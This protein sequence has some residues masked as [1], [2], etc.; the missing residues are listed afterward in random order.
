M[1]LIELLGLKVFSILDDFSPTEKQ[2]L[3]QLVLTPGS[4]AFPVIQ[5]LM[6]NSW[7]IYTPSGAA[8]QMYHMIF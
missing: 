2:H 3:E 5:D 8:E 7:S 1:S 6:V 4:L